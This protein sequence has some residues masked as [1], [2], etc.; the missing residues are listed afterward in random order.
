MRPL[1]ALIFS[2]IRLS[3]WEQSAGDNIW[4]QEEIRKMM[5]KTA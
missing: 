1:S 2:E 5:E 3:G 4:A